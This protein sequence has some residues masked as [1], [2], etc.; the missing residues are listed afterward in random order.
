MQFILWMA[1]EHWFNHMNTILIRDGAVLTSDGWV[2]PGY[3]WIEGERITA[4]SAGAPPP[5]LVA[6]ADE[7]I[8]AAHCA[9]MP[10]LVNAHTHLSQTFMR[11]LAGGRPLLP[12][13]RELIWPLQGALTPEDMRLAALLG[14]VENLR[15]GVTKVVNHHKVAATYAHTDA[16]CE[17]AATFGLHFTLARAWTDKGTNAEPANAIL[18]DLE[19]LFERWKD[20][21]KVQIAS[22]PLALWRCSADTLHRSHELA[23]QYGSFTHFHVAESQDE[24]QLSLDETGLRPVSWLQ[25]IGVLGTDTQVVHAV[26]LD[27]AEIDLLAQQNAPVIHCPVS[28]AVLGSG[29]APVMA[30][31]NRG[32]SLRLGTDGPASNDTQD[33]WE[34]MKTAVHF[35]RA[36]TLDATV[37][38]ATAALKLAMSADDLIP[39]APADLI[40]VNLNHPRAMPVHDVASALALSTHGSDVETVIVGGQILLRNRQVLGLDEATLLEDCRRAIVHLRQRAG[41]N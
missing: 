13:L 39:G 16:V 35:A 12:W 33:V 5:T 4:V 18:A 1:G 21:N 36:S 7:M 14:L 41:I 15:G 28:N 10:G 9:V 8:D 25:D 23:Q 32:V 38:P 27:E 29:I 31:L 34:T 17:V 37:L 26:W 11:G 24:V 2:E 6:Q 30:M 40:V 22:G 19:R 20:A 3:V